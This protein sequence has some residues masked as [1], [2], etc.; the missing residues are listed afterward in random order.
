M[1]KLIKEAAIESL[2]FSCLFLIF[3]LY[4]WRFGDLSS[5]KNVRWW[6]IG[7][8]PI[9]SLIS[10]GPR[11]ISFWLRKRRWLEFVKQGSV[12]DSFLS[13]K[14]M[15]FRLWNRWS[16]FLVM[17]VMLNTIILWFVFREQ[18]MTIFVAWCILFALTSGSERVS[19]NF[20]T[21]YEHQRSYPL[22]KTM[23]MHLEPPEDLVASGELKEDAMLQ[24]VLINQQ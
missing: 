19:R 11:M 12:Y 21:F 8:G 16:I 3:C 2:F 24:S 1:K 7:S 10:N 9:I 14:A 4:D 22:G 17:T 13:R 23:A 5:D 20:F 18:Y 6:T 15:S